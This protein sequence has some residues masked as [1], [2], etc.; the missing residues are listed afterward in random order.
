MAIKVVRIIARLN[1]GGPARH[2]LLLSEGLRAHG[3]ETLLLSG[4][5]GPGEAPIEAAAP[6]GVRLEQV[7]GLGPTPRPG[8][9]LRALAA[10]VRILRRERPAI[11]HTHTA[12]A[13][14]LGR[15]AA[16][17]AGVPLVV[18]TFH[19]HVL[20]NYFS[21]TG[22]RAARLAERALARLT[23]RIV[24]LS[25]GLARELAHDL[26]VGRPEQYAVVPLGRDLA[27]LRAARPGAL[28]AELGLA[29]DVPLVLG[30]GRLVPIKDV[31][32][33]VRAF[34]RLRARA[35]AARLVLV[36]DGDERPRVLAAVRA[37]GLEPAVHLLGWRRDLPALLADADLLAL[38]SKNEGTPLAIVE[39]FAAGVPVV[40]TAVGGVPD[41][42]VPPSG[43]DAQAPSG[44]LARAEGALV[45]P[46][47]QAEQAL[48][49]A[50]AWALEPA[51]RAR[52]GAA[53]RRASARW[54]A[55]RLLEDVAALYGELLT[56][57]GR[58][59]P[60]P[61]HGRP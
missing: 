53:A 33:L 22:S 34:A 31:P 37:E 35:P 13:G 23:D 41:M 49:D 1:L 29:P 28:R 2:C 17:L 8:A 7:P 12:K 42:F 15:V 16:R 9:D 59:P 32:A 20:T 43:E 38:A 25:P 39:A 14:A 26:G 11:V 18:H 56:A 6:S 36:G 50:M 44:V 21:P 52:L 4:A 10:L 27:P 51:R 60:A 57:A 55:P 58:S 46:G 47:P 3:Y 40:A 61:Y 5:L 54:D 30:V 24:T 45:A 19:G 48:A